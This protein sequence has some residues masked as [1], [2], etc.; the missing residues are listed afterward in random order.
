M[1]PRIMFS[2]KEMR[3]REISEEEQG[4]YTG[5][6]CDNPANIEYEVTVPIQINILGDHL[7][8]LQCEEQKIADENA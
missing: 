4:L 8:D 1:I 7:F 2:R 3:K 5:L 6:P